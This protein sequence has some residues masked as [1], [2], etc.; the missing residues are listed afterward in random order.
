MPRFKFA[1]AISI[2]A[3]VCLI[4]TTGPSAQSIPFNKRGPGLSP[5]DF[6]RQNTRPRDPR[7]RARGP[8]RSRAIVRTRG[9]KPPEMLALYAAFGNPIKV[10]EY[11]RRGVNV[12]SGYQPA[13]GLKGNAL[14]TAVIMDHRTIVRM[15][16]AAGANTKFTLHGGYTSPEWGFT[17]RTPI[18]VAREMN[19]DA[20]ARLLENKSKRRIRVRRV[21]GLQRLMAFGPYSADKQL[22]NGGMVFDWKTNRYKRVHVCRV[23]NSGYTSYGILNRNPSTGSMACDLRRYQR[24]RFR[25]RDNFEV[26]YHKSP[27]R[28]NREVI[29][30]T[31]HKTSYAPGFRL[32]NGKYL[33][34][35]SISGPFTV[36][37]V[38]RDFYG[39]SEQ[40]AAQ[41]RKGNIRH[42]ILT[43]V[44]TE[45]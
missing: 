34:R 25:L 2:I 3:A 17:A 36:S 13:C 26:L 33:I 44:E 7:I 30:Q 40:T 12:N 18:Q 27:L 24:H 29:W 8:V 10:Q 1:A 23:K 9:A 35:T 5:E 11:I 19:N 31:Q 45:D 28:S 43:M 22:V 16:L 37:G 4:I 41:A 6:R 14:F 20:M 15:L 21:N 32:S 42:E 39:W 38:S